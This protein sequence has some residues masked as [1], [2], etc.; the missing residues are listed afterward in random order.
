MKFRKVMSALLAGAM[1]L[2]L[3][4]TA[5]ASTTNITTVD[6]MTEGQVIEV[7]GTTKT[8]DI[9]ITVPTSASII[10]NPYE[11]NVSADATPITGQVISA[12]QAIKNESDLPV[13][14]TTT[15][16]GTIEG[17]E[18]ATTSAVAETTKKVFLEFGVE[19][20][21]DVTAGNTPAFTSPTK[22]VL[23]TTAVTFNPVTLTEKGGATS[24]MAFG[25]TGDASK[26]PTN[27]WTADDIVGATIAFTFALDNSGNAGGGG[28]PTTYTIGE[29][30]HTDASSDISAVSFEVSGTAVTSAAENDTV[31]I[32]VTATTGK[33]ITAS[34][35][36]G[37]AISL[38]ESS[39]I[40]TGTFTMPAQNA[41]VVLTVA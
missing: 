3:S 2:S 27:A 30:T 26:N 17:A 6:G 41:T 11:L 39:G 20:I 18:F 33:T 10:L 9:K 15:V 37:S 25:F 29:G 12:V 31:T 22:K 28:G 13:K 32:K 4:S 23:S 38:A 34:V 8:A 1:V 14:V 24:S 7:T 16:T 19:A 21:A 5:F 36:G 40:Y 35:N